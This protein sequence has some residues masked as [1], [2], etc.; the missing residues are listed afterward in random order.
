MSKRYS[1]RPSQ[2]MGIEDPYAAWCYDEAVYLWDLRV[3]NEMN[4]AEQNKRNQKKDS[5]TG[6]SEAE[7]AQVRD[8]AFKR[9]MAL[10]TDGIGKD[11]PPP[12]ATFRDPASA[13][14]G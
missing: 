12:K 1:C 14:R 6:V 3:N 4:E 9:M 13:V 10:T 11:D 2:L 7:V 5:K 8:S